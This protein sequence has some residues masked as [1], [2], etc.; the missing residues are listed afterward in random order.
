MKIAMMT[1]TITVTMIVIEIIVIICNDDERGN[2][3]KITMVI[4][5]IE[6]NVQ[7]ERC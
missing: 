3:M 7:S 2:A 5:A 6:A 4:V 1:I